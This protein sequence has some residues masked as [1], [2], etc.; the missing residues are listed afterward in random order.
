[1]QKVTYDQDVCGL[2]DALIA[3]VMSD[4]EGGWRM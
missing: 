4:V 1:M 3:V 2:K